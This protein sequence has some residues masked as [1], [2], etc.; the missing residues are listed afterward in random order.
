MHEV[1]LEH[2]FCSYRRRDFF[3][4][5]FLPRGDPISLFTAGVNELLFAL[6]RGVIGIPNFRVFEESAL[7]RAGELSSCLDELRSWRAGNASCLA[8]KASPY[9]CVNLATRSSTAS[10]I[11]WGSF[12]RHS[13][14]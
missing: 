13:E 8:V 10:A 2:T 14:P 11:P 9:S 6:R 3:V 12:L 5:D 1:I 4:G 7:P